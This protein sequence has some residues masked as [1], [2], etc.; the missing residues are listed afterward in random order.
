M[1]SSSLSM[2]ANSFVWATAWVAL[3]TA[4][5]CSEDGK[6][7][8][9]GDDDDSGA[10]GEDESP[11]GRGGT[12]GR[13]SSGGS[14]GA[15]GS[16]VSTGGRAGA[17]N[18]SGGSAEGGDDASGGSS[19]GSGASATGGGAGSDAGG[20][21]G[22][23]GDAG[24]SAGDAGS[25]S[26]GDA[27]EG[28][29]GRA[30]SSG[31]GGGLS[32]GAS[33][34][35]AGGGSAGGGGD[36][37]GSGAS[38][39]GGVSGSSGSSGSGGSAGDGVTCGKALEISDVGF[40]RTPVGGG[41]CWHGT[42]YAGA[43]EGSPSTKNFSACGEGCELRFAATLNASPSASAYVG[44]PL[45]QPPDSSSGL[46]TPVV[47]SALRVSFSKV[48]SFEMR[49]MIGLSSTVWCARV[50]A[51]PA[52]IPWSSFNTACWDNSG[53]FF[54]GATIDRVMISIPGQSTSTAFDVRIL[55][56]TTQ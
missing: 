13:T 31:S 21:Q 18:A 32:G 6:K 54:T 50:T 19:A 44:F 8:H 43:Q 40:V 34:A 4:L 51:S 14:S 20:N 1:L 35:G 47:G 42:A 52:V 38:G 37:G 36:S 55:D 29:G 15:A 33:G 28:M 12:A 11:A 17:S 48:G 56:V 41:A 49:V 53:S 23:A 7:R 2:K 5:A 46:P 10:G 16:V 27:G 25:G 3:F 9:R 24:A 22:S 39:T 45:N 30:G 26:G